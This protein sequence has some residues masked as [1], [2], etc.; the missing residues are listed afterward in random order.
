[1]LLRRGRQHTPGDPGNTPIFVVAGL[2]V[3][4]DSADSLLM[5]YVKLKTRF[6][7]SLHILLSIQ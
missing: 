7:P 5:D 3:A 4:A 2:T 1:V 6:E